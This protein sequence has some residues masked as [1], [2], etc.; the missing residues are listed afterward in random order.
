M[1]SYG[2]G[3]LQVADGFEDYCIERFGETTYKDGYGN[4]ALNI[5][6]RRAFLL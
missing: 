4:S 1:N 2:V 5:L 3:D 6:C